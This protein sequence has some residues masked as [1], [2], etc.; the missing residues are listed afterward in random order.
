MAAGTPSAASSAVLVAILS[1]FPSS[2]PNRDLRPAIPG[3]PRDLRRGLEARGH[4]FSTNC[5]VEVV[6]HLWEELGPGC[7][8][9]LRG[10]FALAIWDSRS[11]S[12]FLA[13]DRVGKKPLYYRRMAAG[14][15]LFAFQAR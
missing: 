9:P 1:F 8:E 13:R 10:M 15:L 12:L 5:D 2:G 3:P 4:S 11:R 7:L 6:L 14:G